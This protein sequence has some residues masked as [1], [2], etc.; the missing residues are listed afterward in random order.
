M[1]HEPVRG[2][3][4]ARNSGA[5]LAGG[6]VLVFVDADVIVP[7]EILQKIQYAVS[8]PDCVEEGSSSNAG[9]AAFQ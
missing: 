6:E 7:P 5:Q 8:D 9:R 3:S 2:I 1:I 4:R